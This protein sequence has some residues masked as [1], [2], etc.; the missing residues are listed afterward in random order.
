M[1]KSKTK[2]PECRIS[3]EK[4]AKALNHPVRIAILEMLQISENGLA[5]HQIIEKCRKAANILKGSVEQPIVSSHLKKL[6]IAGFVDKVPNGKERIYYIDDV[7]IAYFDF[8]AGKWLTKDETISNS[9][10]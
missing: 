9:M 6:L 8:L 4:A 10:I 5:V 3:I 2:M 7:N 1:T